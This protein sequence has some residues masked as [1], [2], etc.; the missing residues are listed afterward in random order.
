MML[1]MNSYLKHSWLGVAQEEGRCYK[2]EFHAI[3]SKFLFFFFRVR[4]WIR[5]RFRV[6]VRFRCL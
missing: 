3:F 1:A 5:V 2:A 4:L 6:T